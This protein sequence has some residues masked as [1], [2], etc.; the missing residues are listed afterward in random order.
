[1]GKVDVIQLRDLIKF[2]FEKL[3]TVLPRRQSMEKKFN[4]SKTRK[5][6]IFGSTDHFFENPIANKHGQMQIRDIHYMQI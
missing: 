4:S 3:Q 1:M 6:R 5:I 2:F